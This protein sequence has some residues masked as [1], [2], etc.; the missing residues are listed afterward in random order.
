MT[1]S[2]LISLSESDEYTLWHAPDLSTQRNISIESVIAPIASDNPESVNIE[3]TEA[4]EDFPEFEQSAQEQI[5]ELQQTM[6]A[7]FA[8]QRAQVEKILQAM[9]NPL[10]RVNTAVERELVELALAI[11]KL[12]LKTEISRKPEYLITLVQDAIKQLPAASLNIVVHLHP[13]D[14]RVVAELAE[15]FDSQEDWSIKED[16]AL[17]QGE[18]HIVT[19][20]SFIDASVDGLVNRLAKDMLAD[21]AVT[22]FNEIETED[23]S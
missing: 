7:E 17:Q 6:E 9:T 3:A 23:A 11:A 13:N 14:A 22:D 15:G 16:A 1:M 21:Y 8:Q 2:R 20:T 4:D 10:D 12:I 18:C 19:N 5:E